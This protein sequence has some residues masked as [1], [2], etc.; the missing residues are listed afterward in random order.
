MEGYLRGYYGY[1][2]FG[3]E[4]LFFGVVKQ[5]F[6]RYPLTKLFVEVGNVAWMEDWIRENY[7]HILDEKHL[8]A[9][10]CVR[11]HPHRYRW[12]TYLLHTIG[13]HRY[14][15]IF[16]FFGGGEVLSDERPFPHD[17]RNIPLLFH[18]NVQKGNFALLGGIGK[19]QKPYTQLLYRYLLP[20]AESIIVRDK[21]SAILARHIV[22]QG[23]SADQQALTDNVY[24]YQD[25]AQEILLQYTA[26]DFPKAP[27]ATPYLLVNINKQS[28][29][30]EYIKQIESFCRD[31]PNH[32]KI[33]FPCDMNDDPH[34]FD[35]LKK[36]IPDL[37]MYDRTRHSLRDNLWLFRHT[38]AGIGA[39]LHFLLP[40][41]LYNKPLHAIPYADKINKVIG[42]A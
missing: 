9:I 1:K 30:T 24:L 2:N 4:L 39:R 12:W 17:G 14:K 15:K 31:Y 29:T 3:D 18:Y 23:K 33:F 32:K 26:K 22:A 35:L 37:E 36:R 42:K 11:A 27:Y 19:P 34:C 41:K 7:L 21:D 16:K 6:T 13:A 10:K 40:L 28:M 20:K 25:F 38:Q 8:K 5:L